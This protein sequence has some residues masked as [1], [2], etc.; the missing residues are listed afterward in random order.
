[1]FWFV[2]RK[3][4]LFS[5]FLPVCSIVSSSL[6]TKKK[7]KAVLANIILKTT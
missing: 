7:E 4:V 3:I 2:W 6:G 1:M 5:G